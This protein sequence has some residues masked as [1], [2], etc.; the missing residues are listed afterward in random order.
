VK[1][2]QALAQVAPTVGWSVIFVRMQTLRSLFCSIV[3]AATMGSEMCAQQAVVPCGLDASG[4]SGQLSMSVGLVGYT[5]V[6]NANG[7]LAQGV[8]HAYEIIVVSIAE[9]MNPSLVATVGPNPTAD[10]VILR[11][12]GTPD[13][14]T[15]YNLHDASGR[16]IRARGVAEQVTAIN[17][18]DLSPGSYL[19]S[20]HEGEL[21]IYVVR[22]IKQ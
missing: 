13:P 6:E 3:I 11:L 9:P 2:Q 18:A 7:R 4:T 8:Q 16:L 14:F 15:G 20:L 21:P 1:V 10:G 22:L 19:F 12:Q 17:L 5:A